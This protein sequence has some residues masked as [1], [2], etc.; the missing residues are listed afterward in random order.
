MSDHVPRTVIG[1]IH[2]PPLPSSPRYAGE[3]LSQLIDRAS[4]DAERLK[5]AGFD[6]YIVENF[7]DAPFFP[8]AVPPVVLTVMTRILAALPKHGLQRGVNVLRN[9]AGGA[10]A[11]AAATGADFI[12]VNV[13]VGVMATDQG[14]IEGKAAETVR[15]QRLV[16]PE[17]RIYADV[18]VKHAHPVSPAFDLAEAARETAYRGLADGIIVS[19]PATGAAASLADVRAVKAAVPDRPVWVGSGVS[20]ATVGETLAH[21]DGIIVGTALKRDGRVDLPID[22][23]R[24]HRFMDAVRRV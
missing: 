21:A 14:F 9:D 19:G 5:N 22:S 13:H 4:A 3:S 18:D 24:A 17:V 23:D 2:L 12:R 16:A 7:G 8:T 6:G 10:L 1:V 20:A 15:L 11:V